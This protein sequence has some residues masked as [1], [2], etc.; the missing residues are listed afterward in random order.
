[1]DALHL[2]EGRAPGLEGYGTNPQVVLPQW[3]VSASE[4]DGPIEAGRAQEDA[5]A[6]PQ[7]VGPLLQ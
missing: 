4:E 3:G 7:M 1:M 6:V 2:V 5:I